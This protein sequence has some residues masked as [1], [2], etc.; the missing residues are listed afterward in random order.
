MPV[1]EER[2]NLWAQ[3]ISETEETKCQN[4]LS[5]VTEALRAPFGNSVTILRKGSHANRTNIRADSDVDIAA[6]HEGYF[7]DDLQRLS[8]EEKAVYESQ[9]VSADYAYRTFKDD[10]QKALADYFG[11]ENVQRKTKC[12]RVKGNTNR[13]DSDV[14]PS[15]RYKRF[16]TPTHVE[17]VGIALIPDNSPNVIGSFPEQ[18]YAN[19]VSKNERTARNFKAVVRVLK[20]ARNQMVD[21]GLFTRDAMSS[22]FIECLVWNAADT[23]FGHATHRANARAVGAAVWND[24]RDTLRSGAYTEASGLLW[25]FRDGRTPAQ[26]EAFMS[27]VWNCL[28]A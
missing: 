22:F 16:R 27:A 24:M 8:S 19:G 18:H 3:A 14:V 9:R 10:V 2:I 17:A 1:S 21:E 28:A 7:F 26:A 15:Y 20:N 6:I 11:A 5:Q 13:V 23:H 12:I 25:L 4:A